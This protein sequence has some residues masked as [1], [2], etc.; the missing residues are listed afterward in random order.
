[1]LA[2]RGAVAP[3][4]DPAG[5]AREMANWTFPLHFIDFETARPALPF[6]RGRRPYETIAF[7]FS[8]HVIHEN[9]R[10]EHRG[11]WISQ[12]KGTFPNFEFVRRLKQDLETDSGTILRYWDHDNT[13][14]IEIYRQ[15]QASASLEVPDRDELSSWIQTV[16]HSHHDDPPWHGVRAMVDMGHLVR[17]YY[18]HPLQRGSN[19]LKAVLPAILATSTY[20]QRKYSRPIYG[21]KHEM[22]S[23]N[24]EK[25]PIAWV[26]WDGVNVRDPYALLPRIFTDYDMRTLERLL[27]ATDIAE[28]GAAMTAYGRM[29]FTEMSDTERQQIA[30]ALLRYG[31]LDTLAMVMLYEHWIELLGQLKTDE[32][33]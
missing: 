27:P 17:R 13:T 1:M 29:Q 16:T 30:A 22:P 2:S 32:A 23:L 3:Y 33:A 28:G 14:L 6:N 12:E 15:L 31:E 5:L 20:L 9:G 25:A 21:V 18:L 24:F 10:I 4:V 11:Q 19:S 8:H 26:Q 7:Q